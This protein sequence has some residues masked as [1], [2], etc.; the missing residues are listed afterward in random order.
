MVTT[1]A[2]VL[3]ISMI[4]QHDSKS[5]CCTW[6]HL[7]H[8]MGAREI[9][10]QIS[11]GE[12]IWWELLNPKVAIYFCALPCFRWWY[13][14]D[15]TNVEDLDIRC[16]RLAVRYTCFGVAVQDF[17]YIV[18]YVL[19]PHAFAPIHLFRGSA[20]NMNFSPRAWWPWEFQHKSVGSDLKL[21]SSMAGVP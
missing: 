9:F 19:I 7:V 1:S 15:D 20:T 11:I 21:N 16:E 10:S 5:T 12:W 18:L 13:F 17:V 4:C 2:V 3:W 6:Q 14:A 8:F